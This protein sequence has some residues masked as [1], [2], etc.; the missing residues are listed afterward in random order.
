MRHGIVS[1]IEDCG[2]DGVDTLTGQKDE[3]VVVV[4]NHHRFDLC[5]RFFACGTSF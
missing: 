5:I 2:E 1:K 3:N 4:K